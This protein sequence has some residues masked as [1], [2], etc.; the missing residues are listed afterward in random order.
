M[1][2]PRSL[3]LRLSLLF[4]IVATI[5]FIIFGLIVRQ[6]IENHFHFED[7]KELNSIAHEVEQSLL[8]LKPNFDL[9]LIKQRFDDLMIG[10]HNPQMHIYDSLGNQ[11]YSNTELE[12]SSIPQPSLIQLS[13]G[14]ILQWNS[15]H[16][17]YRVLM[18]KVVKQINDSYTIVIAVSTD[19]HR[20]FQQ[21]FHRIL[22][23]M[24][25]CSI[26]VMGFMGWLVVKHGHRPLHRM[27]K[28]IATI[29]ANDLTSR[30]SPETVP[31]ELGELAITFN[32]L[33]QR[34][35]ESFNRLTEFS[36][37]IAH[38]L[39]TPITNLVTQTQVM[40]SQSRAVE[41]YKETL[42]SSME[43]YQ[44]MAQMINDMLFLAKTD[45]NL[46]AIKTNNIDLRNEVDNLL[47]YYSDWAE[48]CAVSIS[49]EGHV[50]IHCD[51]LMMRRALSNLLSN[52]IRHTPA[53][54]TVHVR[55][56]RM[57]NDA[58]III[59]NLGT[60][61]PAEHLSKLFDRFYR[62]DPSRQHRH[63][64]AGLGLAITK[65][66]IELH[67]GKIFVTSDETKTEFKI[68]CPISHGE[69]EIT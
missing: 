36:A 50:H 5:V 20:R 49:V 41:E 13:Q 26:A 58:Y 32:N 30:I 61:I 69:S 53:G 16:H 39:R 9:M 68:I 22:W 65:S 31:I 28:Q 66:I 1:M 25:F 43:E 45:N 37:D 33:M 62:I 38:E 7:S 40:L 4:G 8:T 51:R 15:S 55:L 56:G 23:L 35:E 44:R 6:A 47:D 14:T 67:G 64:E 34:L 48:E 63:E 57:A 46:H 59:H 12:F 19:F 52:A 54:K 42:Y 3:T 10:H 60:P 11:L 24:I 27:V 21:E 18:K 17:D 2:Q 29:N